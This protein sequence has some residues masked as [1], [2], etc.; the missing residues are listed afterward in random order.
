M[1]LGEEDRA[2]DWLERAYEERELTIPFL[3]GVRS[4]DPLHGHLRFE[5]IVERMNLGAR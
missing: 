1:R 5:A 3:L 4:L 2:L